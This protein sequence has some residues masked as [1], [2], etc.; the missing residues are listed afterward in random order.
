M[1]FTGRPAATLLAILAVLIATAAAGAEQ[2]R[3]ADA[4][5]ATVELGS[6]RE[7]AADEVLVRYRGSPR[8]RLVR[9]ESG[10]GLRA[11]L[12]ELRADP[13]VRWAA[14]NAIARTSWV[15]R[16]PGRTGTPGGWQED[17]WNFLAPPAVGTPCSAAAPCGVNAPKAWTLLRKAGHPKGRRADGRRGPLV[18][19]VDTGVAY[20]DRGR[21]H[22]RSPDLEPGTFKR[23]KDFV[24]KNGIALDR[25]GHGTHVASTI[26]ERT[27]NRKAMTGLADGLRMMPVRV[28]DANGSGSAHDVAKGIRWA[29]RQGAKVIN[30][31]LEFGPGFDS[32]VGLRGVCRAIR[33][34]RDKKG[35]VVVAAAGNA[36]SP[37]AQMPAKV[38]FGVTSTTIRGCI[39]DFASR[40][41]GTDIA[42]PGGGPDD[43]KG[44]SHCRP[45][46]PSPPIVQL[47]L[48]KGAAASGNFRRFGYPRFEGTSMAVPHVSA[49]AALVLASG[50]LADR[51]GRQPRPR[52]VESWITCNARPVHDASAA[53]QYGAGLLDLAAALD[54]KSRCT[55]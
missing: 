45:S 6:G 26:F 25:N 10:T 9:V 14:P 20:R 32:C 43:P 12:R 30:L 35:A 55:T 18:A 48:T 37:T 54:P 23:G 1:T 4:G 7:A 51:L 22:R 27:G 21:K 36:N 16:D 44:G 8:E 13:D 2:T 24:G 39:S 11:T 29:A 49:T 42:A 3:A 40:G 41:P 38:A 17:Q 46:A 47:T 31:S 34:A 15:P 52:E 33:F 50:V 53:A 28:L 5:E 19:I